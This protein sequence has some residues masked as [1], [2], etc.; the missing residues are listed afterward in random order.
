M[1]LMEA[2]F[3]NFKSENH[4]GIHNVAG[5]LSNPKFA[6]SLTPRY[7]EFRIRHTRVD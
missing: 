2:A 6:L 7:G 1:I 5:V 3:A 4:T